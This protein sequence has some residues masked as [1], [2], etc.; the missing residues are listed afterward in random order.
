MTTLHLLEQYSRS[1]NC[2]PGRYDL[3]EKMKECLAPLQ[4]FRL[5]IAEDMAV[6]T[7]QNGGDK[8]VSANC[9]NPTKRR[10][11]MGS[12][13]GLSQFNVDY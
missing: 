9:V 3:K 11:V 6:R 13:W 5:Q 4:S 2:D 1:G 8:Y 7:G 10:R 12:K